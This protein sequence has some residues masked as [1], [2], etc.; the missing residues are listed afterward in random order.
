MFVRLL[1]CKLYDLGYFVGKGGILK[2]LSQNT[3]LGQI[4]I[5]KFEL[6]TVLIRSGEIWKS[7]G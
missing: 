4:S 6:K 5:R 2:N 7:S 1:L 3:G